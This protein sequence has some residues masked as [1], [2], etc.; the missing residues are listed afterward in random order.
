MKDIKFIALFITQFF[1]WT[2]SLAQRTQIDSLKE[3]L[4][5]AS[6]TNRINCLNALGMSYQESQT[7][8]ALFYSCQA[9]SEAKSVRYKKGVSDAF[10][11][12]G[13]VY[14]RRGDYK[15]AEQNFNLSINNYEN[16]L[17]TAHLG[18][19]YVWLGVSL[20][21][22]SY[23]QRATQA[24]LKADELFKNVKDVQGS[25]RS[26]FFLALNYEENGLYEKAFELNSKSLYEAKKNNDRQFFLFS[27][28]NTGRLYQNVG[29]YQTALDYYHQ[30]EVYADKY[31]LL[32]DESYLGSK[33][34]IGEVYCLMGNFDS[35]RYYLNQALALCNASSKDS[36]AKK[37]I[38]MVHMQILGEFYLMQKDYD[39]ALA[40]FSEPMK[41]YVWGNNRSVLM[42]VLLNTGKAYEGKKEYNVALDYARRVLQMAKQT[43]ARKFIRDGTGLIWSIYDQLGIIDSAYHYFR[44]YSVM[45]DSLLSTRYIRQLALYKDQS[46]NERRQ[47]QMQ[48]ALQNE[49][50]SV[51]FA[52]SILFIV[53]L[54]AFIIILFI[55]L[56]H[57]NEKHLRKIAENELQIQKHEN[58]KQLTE[59]EMQALRAQMNP[60]FIF[61]SLNSINRFILQNNKAEASGY[62]TKF[63][64]LVRLILQNS[65]APLI[66]LESELQSLELYLDLEALR[67]DHHFSYKISVSRDLEISALKVPPLII[68]PYAENAIW[69][70]LMHKEEKGQL[71]IE[72]FRQD[73]QLCF[74]IADNG[75]GRKQA[76]ALASKSATRYKSMGLRITADRIAMMKHTNAHQSSVTINDLVQPDSSAGGT[77]VIIKIP[78][79]YD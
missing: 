17:N 51:T 42:R 29:D 33:L 73:D 40:S 50:L 14:A 12:I 74:K 19:T 28:L 34:Y 2:V 31:T 67:F 26:H 39:K 10:L 7:D 22:Q 11:V 53:L 59:M 41:F 65:Q 9:L 5:T 62:L 56:K 54:L 61:N 3:V 52:V 25:N 44:Q 79:I 57:K 64:K 76:T 4:L 43:G 72:V 18:W 66:P 75:I 15:S 21:A 58:Q 70:G 60:H 8:S 71:D 1:C 37:E 45:K 47:L 46:E 68:Q 13:N 49:S 23:F 55:T 30:S 20:Y 27:L 24:F 6:D 32:P 77:E 35:S 48:L 38:I 36:S 63:S 78:V 16:K 69:H